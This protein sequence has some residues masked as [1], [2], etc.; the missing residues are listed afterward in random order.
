[1]PR[2]RTRCRIR[3]APPSAGG[4][5]AALD[6]R[7]AACALPPSAR[8]DPKALAGQ[9]A[10]AAT[11]T[12]KAAA[13]AATGGKR[14]RTPLRR[15]CIRAAAARFKLWP[16]RFGCRKEAKQSAASEVGVG[17]RKAD[18]HVFMLW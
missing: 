11:A 17:V 5:G 13:S 10:A 9:V 1:M 4:F 7:A 2:R 6:G 12:A 15:R 8:G 18:K 16:S 14:G 3:I